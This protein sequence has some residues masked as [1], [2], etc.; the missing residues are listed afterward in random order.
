MYS[1]VEPVHHMQRP[2]SQVC[3]LRCLLAVHSKRIVFVSVSTFPVHDKNK[4]KRTSDMLLIVF[5]SSCLGRHNFLTIVHSPFI[6]V[7][8]YT[9]PARQCLY[10]II[11]L[12]PCLAFLLCLLRAAVRGSV[13]RLQLSL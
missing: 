11:R 4:H 5:C 1:L 8:Y 12:S 6:L 10:I 3:F 13:L 7:F 2:V 9:G